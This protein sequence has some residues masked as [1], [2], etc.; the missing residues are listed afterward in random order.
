M[1][2]RTSILDLFPVELLTLIKEAIPQGDIQTH[3]CFYLSLPPVTSSLYGDE[4]Q[5]EKFWESACVQ[6]GLG[7]LPGETLNPQDISWKRIAFECIE[8]DGF[9]D[10]VEC[11]SARLDANGESSLFGAVSWY[12]R[13]CIFSTRHVLSNRRRFA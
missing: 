3:V 6:A 1:A 10:H 5:E 11:G 2:P 12:S 9:C 4:E 8:F 7:L 13:C